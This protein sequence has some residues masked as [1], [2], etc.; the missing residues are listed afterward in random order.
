MSPGCLVQLG[1]SDEPPELATLT[2]IDRTCLFDT[3][4]DA[5]RMRFVAA[6]LWI[7]PGTTATVLEVEDHFVRLLMPNG[8][9]GW[10]RK[11]YWWPL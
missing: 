7:Q 1:R 5:K 11:E 8:K 4:E 3:L 6:L 2:Q 10:A 9:S